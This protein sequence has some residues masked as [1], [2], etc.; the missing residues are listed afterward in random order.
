MP[1]ISRAD[2]LTLSERAVVKEAV[3]RDLLA[4]GL[5]ESLAV[6]DTLAEPDSCLSGGIQQSSPDSRAPGA[7]PRDADQKS[8]GTMENKALPR[9]LPVFCFNGDFGADKSLHTAFAASGKHSSQ[10][11]LCHTRGYAWGE[12]DILDPEVADTAMVYSSLLSNDFVNAS[13][14]FPGISL[15]LGNADDWVLDT[16]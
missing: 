9:A 1:V 6:F 2:T 14:R 16:R 12:L 13:C 3:R 11:S 4:A 15:V 10:S 7:L 5:S 8:E